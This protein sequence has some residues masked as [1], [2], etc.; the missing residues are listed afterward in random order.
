M[1]N[2]AK[3]ICLS[4]CFNF[5][6]RNFN[7]WIRWHQNFFKNSNWNY[8]R[9]PT[10]FLLE[11]PVKKTDGLSSFL[12]GAIKFIYSEKATKVCEICTVDLSYVV[13]VEST[14]EILQNFVAFSEYMNFMRRYLKHNTNF[15]C[16]FL[17]QNNG[18]WSKWSNICNDGKWSQEMS[19]LLCTICFKWWMSYNVVS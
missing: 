9:I 8:F 17:N 3:A 2:L 14:V 16:S 6:F 18:K 12:P 4:D 10:G 11:Y 13:R 15:Y 5:P 7:H 1:R 19:P